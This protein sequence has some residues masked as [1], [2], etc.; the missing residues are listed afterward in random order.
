VVELAKVI[1]EYGGIY[2]SHIRNEGDRV[3]E[4]LQEAVDVGLNAHI[5]VEISHFKVMG[6][7][8]WDKSKVTLGMVNDSRKAGL[9]I[10]VDQYPYCA[11]STSLGAIFPIWARAGEGWVKKAEDPEMRKK[12]RDD[13]AE[14]LVRNYTAEGLNRIQLARYTADTTLE[15][16]GIE[17]ILKLRG[18]EVN[19]VN[20]AELIMQLEMKRNEVVYHNMAEEDVQRIMSDPLTMHGSDG[21]IT[22]MNTG[23]P[24]PRCYGTFPRV[25]GVYV[26]EKKLLSLEDAIRKMTSMP[27]ARIGIRDAGIIAAGKRADIVIFDPGTIADKASYEKPH[28]YP[29]GIDYVLVSGEV[30]VDHGNITGKRPGRIMYGPGWKK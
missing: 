18:M 17:D 10:T 8:N 16:K 3:V 14:I 25:L 27:A 4:S 22:E 28:Q 11:S 7:V 30:V 24:H 2:V 12:I 20:G 21:H 29:V 23:V 26:R 5:P 15:G 19:P 1:A 9:D 13:L 6:A